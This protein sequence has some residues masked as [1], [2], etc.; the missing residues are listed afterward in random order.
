M[1]HLAKALLNAAAFFELADE[2]A[3]ELE[4]SVK[5]LEQIS[6]DLKGLSPQEHQQLAEAAQE[7]AA[8][9]RAAGQAFSDRASF[10]ESFFEAFG[11]EQGH[12]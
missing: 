11:V 9:A 3:L 6:Y 12:E 5:A 1:K 10:F 2:D 8:E 7:L 4:A